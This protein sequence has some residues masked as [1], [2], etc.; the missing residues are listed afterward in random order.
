MSYIVNNDTNFY[1]I[2]TNKINPLISHSTGKALLKYDLITNESSLLK[3]LLEIGNALAHIHYI[4]FD[5]G[6]CTLD[7][8][9]IIDNKFT[10]FDFNAGSLKGN[11]KN[12]VHTLLK[13][14]VF[15][16]N[17]LSTQTDIPINKDIERLILFLKSSTIRNG[18]ILIDKVIQYYKEYYDEDKSEDEII[19]FMENYIIN[20]M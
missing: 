3:L 4:G 2:V 10:L 11:S 15:N 6:D 18:D 8:I 12:D 13:S 1:G 5:H 9:G 16:I 14:I 7:N 19:D 20:T 17:T